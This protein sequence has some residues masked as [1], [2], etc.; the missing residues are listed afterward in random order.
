MKKI[1]D[2][3]DA[4]EICERLK[5]IRESLGFKNPRIFAKEIGVKYTTYLYYEKNRIPP[6]E[7]LYVLKRKY[8][9]KV[10]IDWILTGGDE[11]NNAP[12]GILP[13]EGDT[14]SVEL[15]QMVQDIISSDTSYGLSLKVNIRSYHQAVQTETL[16]NE[17]E[18]RVHRLESHMRSSSEAIPIT[19]RRRGQ[20]RNKNDPDAIPGKVD[21]RTN[22]DRRVAGTKS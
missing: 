8:P 14:E 10:N 12:T 20:R 1:F 15:M 7:F 16:Q 2:D 5:H 13:Y 3:I 6:S 22:P 21:R 4:G 18:A 17:L 19:D 11:P 9:H